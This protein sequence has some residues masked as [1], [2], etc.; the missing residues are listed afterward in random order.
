MSCF[1]VLIPSFSFSD[2]FVL[3]PFLNYFLFILL[4]ESQK[5]FAQIS[6]LP[7]LIS[8]SLLFHLEYLVGRFATAWRWNQD[9]SSQNLILNSA[10]WLESYL[11]VFISSLNTLMPALEKLFGIF[12]SSSKDEL[13]FLFGFTPCFFP[14]N[15][16]IYASTAW[17][18]CGQVVSI[19][20]ETV[21]IQAIRSALSLRCVC[22]GTL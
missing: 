15:C 13:I 7:H 12:S 6:D 18:V 4:S 1:F 5:K 3:P 8:P 17:W 22:S 20:G 21:K 14:Y 9:P 16:C 2:I 19:Y 10:D 11:I